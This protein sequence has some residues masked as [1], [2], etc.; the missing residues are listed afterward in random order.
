MNP[1]PRHGGTTI[2]FQIQLKASKAPGSKLIILGDGT[3][4][5]NPSSLLGIK[6]GMTNNLRSLE[7]L[8]IV[9]KNML[10]TAGVELEEA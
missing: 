1:Q 5:L 8:P 10:K 4:K 7:D 9:L 2:S 6:S 3:V